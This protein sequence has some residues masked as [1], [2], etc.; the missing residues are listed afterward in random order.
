M[1]D[2]IVDMTDIVV[3]IQMGS[4]PDSTVRATLVGVTVRQETRCCCPNL[5]PYLHTQTRHQPL[6]LGGKMAMN[7]APCR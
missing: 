3:I 4:I 7:M 6:V 1:I 2:I 5:Q